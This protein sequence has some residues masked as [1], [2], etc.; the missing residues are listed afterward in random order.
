[1]AKSFSLLNQGGTACKLAPVIG[2]SFFLYCSALTS[3]S[4]GEAIGRRCMTLTN[5]RGQKPA[6]KH[7]GRL[8]GFS[9]LQNYEANQVV[10]SHGVKVNSIPIVA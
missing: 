1:M 8:E 4:A 7:A 3:S 9:L 5:P 6:R 2:G 10:S